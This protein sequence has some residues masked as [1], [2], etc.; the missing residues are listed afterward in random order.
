MGIGKG[1]IQLSPT[2]QPIPIDLPIAVVFESPAIEC[3]IRL[4][5]RSREKYVMQLYSL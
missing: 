1:A 4:L 2:D 5:Y 3:L